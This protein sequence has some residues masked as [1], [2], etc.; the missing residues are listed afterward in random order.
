MEIL[1]LLHAKREICKAKYDDADECILLSRQ[2]MVNYGAKLL[3]KS[4]SK[5]IL[6]LLQ[7]GNSKKRQYAKVRSC[8]RVSITSNQADK[9]KLLEVKTM[10]KSPGLLSLSNIKKAEFSGFKA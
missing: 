3:L 1:N 7:S 5:I 2:N 8:Y 9:K 6:C 4:H 10:T